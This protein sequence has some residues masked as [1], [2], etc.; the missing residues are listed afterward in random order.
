M[1][2]EHYQQRCFVAALAVGLKLRPL[3]D[4]ILEPR[5]WRCWSPSAGCSRPGWTPSTGC[6]C[7]AWTLWEGGTPRG[8]TL[9]SHRRLGRCCRCW[10]QIIWSWG[11]NRVQQKQRKQG[12]LFLFCELYS[13]FIM[14]CIFF[15]VTF[16]TQ[17]I[18]DCINTTTGIYPWDMSLYIYINIEM[19]VLLYQT[20]RNKPSF[21]KM[22]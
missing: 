1:T 14:P 4:W 8:L 15:G 12:L 5:P 2:K 9:E 22:K 20:V 7:P 11:L 21:H 13:V 17:L 16:K 3:W 18:F 10:W 19:C 6:Q